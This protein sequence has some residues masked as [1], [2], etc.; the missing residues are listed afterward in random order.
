LSHN[1]YTEYVVHPFGNFAF[2]QMSPTFV[3]VR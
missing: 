3:R 1:L 2:M